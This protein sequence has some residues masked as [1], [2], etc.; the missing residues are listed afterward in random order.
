MDGCE[1]H[2]LKHS[3]MIQNVLLTF[4]KISINQAPGVCYFWASFWSVASNESRKVQSDF[5]PQE[6]NLYKAPDW[7]QLH[8]SE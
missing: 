1:L 7:Q 8:F 2:K 3:F 4:G 6:E 5:H